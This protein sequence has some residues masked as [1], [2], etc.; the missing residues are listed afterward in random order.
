MNFMID[1]VD[2]FDDLKALACYT[3]KSRMKVPEIF[4]HKGGTGRIHSH[5][6]LDQLQVQSLRLL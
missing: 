1:E 4:G 5:L 2:S 3:M 6:I